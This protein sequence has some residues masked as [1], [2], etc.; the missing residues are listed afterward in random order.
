MVVVAVGASVALSETSGGSTLAAPRQGRSDSTGRS[1]ASKATG[2][3]GAHSDVPTT[4][5]TT[6]PPKPSVVQPVSSDAVQASYV[7]PSA[8]FDLTLSTSGPCWIDLVNRASGA[9]L[10][11]GTMTAGQSKSFSGLDQIYLRAGRMKNLQISIDGIPVDS[12]N[13]GPGAYDLIFQVPTGS[14][15]SAASGSSGTPA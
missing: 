10:Y 4:T 5:T 12:P 15:P 14:S 3:P 13:N 8:P 6:T 11:T 1:R 2:T 7:T 9:V